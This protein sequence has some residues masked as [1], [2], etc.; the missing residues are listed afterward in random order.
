MR[1]RPD[2]VRPGFRARLDHS[3]RPGRKGEDN[4]YSENYRDKIREQNY[5]AGAVL[6][7][8][9]HGGHKTAAK[10]ISREAGGGRSSIRAWPDEAAVRGA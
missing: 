3:S 10:S 5:S 7:N 6:M 9:V 1:A 8:C 2:E 4:I